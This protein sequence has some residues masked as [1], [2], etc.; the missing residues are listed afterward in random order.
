MNKWKNELKRAFEAPGPER[1]RAFLRQLDLPGMPA[2]AFLFSQI[3]YIRKW[4]WCISVLIFAVSVL[5]LVFLPGMVLWLISGLTPLLALTVISES[6]RSE[7]YK[8]AEL[9]MATRFSLKSVTFARLAILGLLDFPLLGILLLIGSWGA[10]VDPLAVALY[11]L[12]PF[13]FTSFT[14]LY[15]VRKFRGQEAMYICSGVSV[16]ISIFLL[17]SHRIIPFIYKEQC[18][19]AWIII[20]AVLIVGNGK[21]CTAMIKRTEELVWNLS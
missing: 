14:G 13:L 10:S 6:G 3:G 2:H 18:L 4:V 20:A 5:G 12:T 11:I 7:R 9:E 1:K 17:L 8:M 21:Q 15:I 19:T 16:G